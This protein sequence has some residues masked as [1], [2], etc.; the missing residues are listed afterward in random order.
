MLIG[1]ARVSTADG[2]QSLAVQRDARQ[3]AVVDAGHVY[4]DVASGVRDD[5][6]GLDRCLLGAANRDL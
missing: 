5:R 6:P 4:H 3:A 2:S 1:S